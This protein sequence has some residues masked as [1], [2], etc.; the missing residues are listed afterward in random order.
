MSLKVSDD[1]IVIFTILLKGRHNSGDRIDYVNEQTAK[2]PRDKVRQ[3]RWGELASWS[4]SQWMLNRNNKRN[5]LF[6]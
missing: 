3:Q 4:V 5:D 6:W 2:T 1:D